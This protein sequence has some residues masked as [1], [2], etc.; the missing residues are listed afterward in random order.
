MDIMHKMATKQDL[1]SEPACVSDLTT[2]AQLIADIHTITIAFNAIT[3][4]MWP[5][6]VNSTFRV[7]TIATETATTNLHSLTK[8]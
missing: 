8:F 1:N 6:H 4:D 3:M 5:L 2:V 7:S